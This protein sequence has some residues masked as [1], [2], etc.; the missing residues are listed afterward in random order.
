MGEQVKEAVG[1]REALVGSPV[2]TIYLFLDGAAVE[3]AERKAVDGENVA[4]VE[5]EPELK[6][7]EDGR[8]A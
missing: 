6:F 4:V 7:V 1:V 8:V 2:G 5:L 3:A